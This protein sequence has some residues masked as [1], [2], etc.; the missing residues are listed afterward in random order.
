[1]SEGLEVKQGLPRL[2]LGNQLHDKQSV[3]IVVCSDCVSSA[4]WAMALKLNR[5]CLVS[6]LAIDCMASRLLRP[7]K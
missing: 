7:C 1:M 6:H 5:D 4:S 3:E 2:T